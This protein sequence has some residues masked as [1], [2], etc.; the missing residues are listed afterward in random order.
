MRSWETSRTRSTRWPSCR[1][2]ADWAPHSPSI[3]CLWSD[4]R[5]MLHR[6]TR[7]SQISSL[8]TAVIWNQGRVLRASW[9][10]KKMTVANLKRNRM[11]QKARSRQ[12]AVWAS[13]ALLE[14]LLKMI[15]AWVENYPTWGEL[16]LIVLSTS[17]LLSKRPAERVVIA[18]LKLVNRSSQRS[19]T[20]KL[21]KKRL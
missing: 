2:A 13:S 20:L 12:P 14:V 17:V 1:W 4:R 10:K 8:R 6:K 18:R 11:G 15:Q 9:S 5:S 21:V 7:K 19:L 3:G 16:A